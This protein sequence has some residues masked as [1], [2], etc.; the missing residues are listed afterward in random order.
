MLSHELTQ[1]GVAPQPS[2]KLESRFDSRGEIVEFLTDGGNLQDID[3]VGKRTSSLVRSWF[4]ETHPEKYR[5]RRENSDSICTEY[6]TD[7][8]NVEDST[9]DDDAPVWGWICPKCET[10]NPMNADPQKCSGRP[11]ACLD[12]HW[13]S[14]LDGEF[15]DSLDCING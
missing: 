11:Y 6:T 5:E 13:V 4:R 14:A 9:I 8:P 15:M 7:V 12:C 1:M 2:Q 3:G 10:M